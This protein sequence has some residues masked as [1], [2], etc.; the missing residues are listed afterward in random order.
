MAPIVELSN[1]VTE[2]GAKMTSAVSNNL[3]KFNRDK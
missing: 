2:L 1:E 3:I